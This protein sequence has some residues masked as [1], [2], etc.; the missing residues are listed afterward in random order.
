MK[1]KEFRKKLNLRK[2]TVTN[3]ESEQQD[4]LRGGVLYVGT[5]VAL[6]QYRTEC[7]TSPV[8]SCPTYCGDT[9]P[10]VC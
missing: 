1:P 6:C 5:S 7:C 8:N 9:H 4:A 3:L 10:C 2:Q